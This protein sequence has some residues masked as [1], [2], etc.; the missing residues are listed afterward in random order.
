M[1][2][3]QGALTLPRQLGLTA[4]GRHVTESPV[5]ELASLRSPQ[6]PVF[7]SGRVRLVSGAA[8]SGA[9]IGGGGGGRS[10]PAA[11]LASSPAQPPPHAAPGAFLLLP[12]PPSP[13]AGT[14]REVELIFTCDAASASDGCE[15]GIA[16]TTGGASS[17]PF[18]AGPHTAV[19]LR[20]PSTHLSQSSANASSSPPSSNESSV[21]VLSVN[22]AATGGAGDAATQKVAWGHTPPRGGSGAAA[23]A[24]AALAP[25]PAPAPAPSTDASASGATSSSSDAATAAPHALRVFVDHSVVEAYAGGGRGVVT[26]RVYP[27]F[28]PGDGEGGDPSWGVALLATRGA[29]NCN[30]RVWELGSAWA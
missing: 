19:L 11:A 7:A 10:G 27:D 18:P 22:R 5:A 25:A 20:V 13:S 21:A 4:D 6:Q 3:W 12:L 23:A 30:V 28:V 26:S 14:Q 16:I 15:V 17:P 9:V 24:A 2:G 8:G 29:A 1:R